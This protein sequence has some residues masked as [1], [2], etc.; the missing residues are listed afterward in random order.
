MV[1]GTST[2]G[3]SALALQ[4]FLG[5]HTGSLG[6]SEGT[7]SLQEFKEILHRKIIFL[8]IDLS[9]EV[10][11]WEKIVWQLFCSHRHAAK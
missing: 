11:F 5:A 6:H 1:A 2:V 8:Q 4:L 7:T 10:T 9:L 3:G